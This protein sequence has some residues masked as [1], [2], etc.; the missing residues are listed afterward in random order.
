MIVEFAIGLALQ[1]VGVLKDLVPQ[2][3]P[4]SDGLATM[5]QSLVN[6]VHSFDSYFPIV[7]VFETVGALMI[8][9]AGLTMWRLAVFTYHQFWGSE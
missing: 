6:G 2:I 3:G 4:A 5:A 1:V 7:T 9:K 8:L